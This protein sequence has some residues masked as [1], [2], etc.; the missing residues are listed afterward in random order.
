MRCVFLGAWSGALAA[1]EA[2][3]IRFDLRDERGRVTQ[4]SYPGKYLLL[5]IGYTSCPDIC[6]TTLY[7]YSEVMRAIKNPDAL[8]PLFV[9]IDPVSDDVGYLN[10]YTRHFDERIIGLTGEMKNIRAL[11]GQLGASFGYRLDGR[12]IEN[13]AP[14]TNYA[15]Y[16]SA[17]IY[18]IS[19]ERKL[20][21]VYDY[22]IGVKGLIEALDTVLGEPGGRAGKGGG[23]GEGVKERGEAGNEERDGAAGPAS[24]KVAA[25]SAAK[26]VQSRQAAPSAP[27]PR[28]AADACPLPAGFIAAKATP[29]LRDFPPELAAAVA[30]AAG[31][32][33]LLNLWAA[34][35]APCRVELP[36]L[37]KLAAARTDLAVHTLNLGDKP[38]DIAALFAKLKL[39][40]LP[41]TRSA[42]ATLLARLG[43]PGLPFT[44]L[45]VDGRLAA[46][47][48]GI[49]DR[50]DAI[51]A[52]AQCHA[53]RR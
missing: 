33:V 7:E 23:S 32:P 38:E 47:R 39:K 9:T 48:S 36:A 16:H 24:E 44:A 6:P 34:W 19:P 13:P 18:L 22:Q 28:Q 17:L 25:T 45:F 14:G 41:Q 42:D 27:S 1:R 8:Q 51:A 29:A 30:D 52:F 4:E 46:S 11:A 43:A 20:L 53:A 15:V 5:A 50:T 31:K 21:D 3:E 35:C 2:R 12:K 40:A 26:S 10:V 37:D 49:L